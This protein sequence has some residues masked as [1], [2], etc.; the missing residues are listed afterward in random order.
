MR[1]LIIVLLIT[2]PV[3]L[4]SQD[5]I[6]TYTYQSLVLN[7]GQREIEVWNT[8]HWGRQDYYRAI[9]Q[10]IEFEIGLS[11]KW[12]TAFYLNAGTEKAAIRTGEN[13]SG[14]AGNTEISFSNEWKYK[15]SDPV[16]NTLGCGLYGEVGISGD[17]LE[18]E[19]KLILDKKIGRTYHALNLVAE[20]EFEAEIENNEV[21]QEMEFAFEV[22]Y[23]FSFNVKPG[24]NIGL[25]LVNKN[26]T[27][28][29]N[30]LERSALFG[31][32]GF[33]YAQD[34]FWINF[35]LLPQLAAIHHAD[36]DQIIDGKILDHYEKL[37]SRLLFS[38]AF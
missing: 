23:G 4:L 29:D 37:E 13:L 19:F 22:D 36:D 14:F 25:E 32:P 16:A 5:R 15:V 18:L 28:S 24:F 8:V 11:S 33:S 38:Y 6:F 31:G 30:G 26:E 17:E 9:R 20:P 1:K 34:R 3:T 35:T 21:E 12:Q 2:W 27:S 7:K 10:R